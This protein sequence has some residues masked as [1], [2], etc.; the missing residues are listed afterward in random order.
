MKREAEEAER[1][2]LA[3]LERQRIAELRRQEE[4]R[5][6]KAEEARVKGIE[7]RFFAFWT[8]NMRKKV[9]E[10]RRK[11]KIAASLKACRVG[12]APLKV[13]TNNNTFLVFFL[14]VVL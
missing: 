8:V 11:E 6:R 4:E 3:E 10:R 2:R 7:R 14:D 1:Q 5:K 13:L 12:A 9:A